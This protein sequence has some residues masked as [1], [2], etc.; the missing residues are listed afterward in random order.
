MLVNRVSQGRN[1]YP[2]SSNVLNPCVH[3]SLIVSRCRLTSNKG[4]LTQFYPDSSRTF[5]GECTRGDFFF[6]EEKRLVKDREKKGKRKR[7]WKRIALVRVLGDESHQVCNNFVADRST[8]ERRLFFADIYLFLFF[9]FMHQGWIP[10]FFIPA[11]NWRQ[12]WRSLFCFFFSYDWS[13]FI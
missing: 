1:R 8:T 7:E 5:K 3:G 10:P 11:S 12:S 4:F 2:S 6:R 13:R 9:F